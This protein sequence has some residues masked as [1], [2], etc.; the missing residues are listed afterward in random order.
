ME[1][2]GRAQE[3]GPEREDRARHFQPIVRPPARVARARGRRDASLI[4]FVVL[5][6]AAV[7][8]VPAYFLIP[9]ERPYVLA[10]Y[11]YAQVKLGEFKDIVGAPGT[12]V[13]AKTVDVRA[14]SGGV[15]QE[16]AVEP[17]QDVS[18]G[19]PICRLHSAELV[20]R[21]EEA[22][23][24]V[25]VAEDS[26]AKA[27]LDASQSEERLERELAEAKATL[28]QAEAKA[29]DT[30]SLYE[31]GAIPKKQLDEAEAEVERARSQVKAKEAELVASRSSA[32]L[33]I[34]TCTRQ[35]AAAR[36]NLRAIDDSIA[37]LV[38][39]SPIS[40]KVLD[41]PVVPG[42]T[43]SQGTV[44]AQVADL[45]R[46]VVKA[47]VDSVDVQSVTV[48]QPVTV[49][50][51]ANSVRGAVQA[52]APRAQETGEG[53][54]VEVTIALDSTPKDV[55]PNSAAYAEIEVRQRSGVPHL[56]RGPF[57]A[58]GQE[59]FVYV[60]EGDRAYQRDVRFGRAYGD[61]VEVLEGLEVG[62]TVIT[63]SYEEF[64]DRREIK[65]LPEGG[66]AQ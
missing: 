47:K 30:L 63:S 39:R 32:A 60:V 13:P 49:T 22:Q 28:G 31:A 7:V 26:L 4:A 6:L 27:R 21:R 62:E 29:K 44:V 12:V 59:M 25:L 58:S 64:R 23:R 20:T 37:D 19:Q 38:V 50:L 18:R 36:S 53:T 45:G 48:G 51:G 11:T 35:L 61:M 40:G 24:E 46:L 8:G 65:V 43:A 54:T 2:G 16:I 66:R 15:V 9:R 17:G 3:A 41:V 33:Q 14:T 57:L 56:P 42:Q 5:A 52:V 1:S 55:P 34:E 10:N